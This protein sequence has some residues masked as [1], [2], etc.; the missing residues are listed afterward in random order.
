MIELTSGEVEGLRV[1]LLATMVV[2]SGKLAGHYAEKLNGR[3]FC[4]WLAIAALFVLLL[5]TKGASLFSLRS[6][7]VSLHT[8]SH[9]EPQQ[10][11]ECGP[12]EFAELVAA[13]AQQKHNHNTG[14]PSQCRHKNVDF[15]AG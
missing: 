2:T 4:R 15:D 7:V 1:A 8:H 6:E 13:P 11:S 12:A 9:I 3:E 5:H 14:R 10:Q